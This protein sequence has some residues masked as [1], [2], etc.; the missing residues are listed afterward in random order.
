MIKTPLLVIKKEA[1]T[2]YR[3]VLVPVDFS[4]NSRSA[5]QM[6]LKI[7]PE[8]KIDFLHVF[9]IVL[10]EQMQ[11]AGIGNN[12][13]HDY[14]IKAEEN[15]RRDLNQFIADIQDGDNRVISREVV[16]GYPAHVVCDHAQSTEPDLIVLGKHGKSGLEELLLG[17]VS[18]HVLEQSSCDVLMTIR[19][20][21]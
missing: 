14:H 10:E 18:R 9:D 13:V 7:A 11:S 3:R 19:A 20:C 16:F 12:L 4:E 5:A 1:I 15:A 2:P 17:S 8:A 21:R 6:A